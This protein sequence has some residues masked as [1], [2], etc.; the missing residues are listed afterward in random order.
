MLFR[1]CY[2]LCIKLLCFLGG[3]GGG[4]G[5]G[6]GGAVFLLFGLFIVAVLV[7]VFLFVCCCLFFK[8]SSSVIEFST[9]ITKRLRLIGVSIYVYIPLLVSLQRGLIGTVV[10]LVCAY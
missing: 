10:A 8:F 3:G 4:S 7:L 6:D 9:G 5:G 2:G 1:R